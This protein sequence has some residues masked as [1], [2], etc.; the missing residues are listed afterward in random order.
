MFDSPFTSDIAFVFRTAKDNDFE[1]LAPEE[2]ALLSKTASDKRKSQFANGRIASAEA[3]AKLGIHTNYIAIGNSGE[4][5]WQSD[6]TGSIT[7][8]GSYAA[9]AVC[10]KTAGRA[11]GIDLERIDKKLEFDIS[12]KF[13]TESELNWLKQP[14]DS[15][16]PLQK[17]IILF[18][19][20]ESV[21]KAIFHLTGQPHRFKLM[22][23]TPNSENSFD[24]SLLGN[25]VLPTKKVGFAI[26]NNYVLSYTCF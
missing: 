9:V 17:V 25:L 7:H 20:K 24:L 5:V 10:R 15:Y 26:K 23:L 22:Q 14:D 18:S 19:C 3:L 11:L 6:V 2:Q 16:S 8:S 21:Y 13:C 1:N 4:P 12:E